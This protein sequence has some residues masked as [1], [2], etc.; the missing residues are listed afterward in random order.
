MTTNDSHD[1]KMTP[2]ELDAIWQRYRIHENWERLYEVLKS[3][4]IETMVELGHPCMEVAGTLHDVGKQRGDADC[5]AWIAVGLEYAY[6]CRQ[7]T[8]RDIGD[9]FSVNSEGVL[10]TR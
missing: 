9:E 5:E 3:V 7:L 10:V 2:S 6:R 4:L 1:G 8:V